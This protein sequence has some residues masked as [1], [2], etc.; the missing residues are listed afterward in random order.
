M[1]KNC[2][3]N[4]YFIMFMSASILGYLFEIFYSL[5]FRNKLVNP[6]FLIGPYCPIY[7]YATL[8]MLIFLVK[9][10]KNKIKLFCY[11][12]FIFSVLEYFTSFVLEKIFNLVL[13]DYTG[14]FLNI[15]GRICFIQAILW[16]ILGIIFVEKLEPLFFKFYIKYKGKILNVIFSIIYAVYI[17]DTIFCYIR[18]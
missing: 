6:G 12:L 17:V 10:K 5:I 8:I 16:G 7:G 1:K 9:Y 13:W 18:G 2:K 14:L 3:I 15:N 4:Y 11:S